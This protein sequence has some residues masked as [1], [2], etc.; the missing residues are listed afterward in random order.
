MVNGLMIA[1]GLR[2]AEKVSPEWF[3]DGEADDGQDG[4]PSCTTD[5][6]AGE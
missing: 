4:R 1:G 5:E 6:G 2:Q 3:E